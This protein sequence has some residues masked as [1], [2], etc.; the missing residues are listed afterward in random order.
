[1]FEFLSKG[2]V[3]I[4]TAGVVAGMAIG[5]AIYPSAADDTTSAT[6]EEAASPES[7]GE[8]ANAQDP[9]VLEA[10]L[11]MATMAAD[12]PQMA[13]SVSLVLGA[14]NPDAGTMIY[15]DFCAA[16]HGYDG[17]SLLPEAPSFADG[18]IFKASDTDLFISVRDGKGDIMPPW[19]D[20]ITVAEMFAALKYAKKFAPDKEPGEGEAAEPAE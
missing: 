7:D 15:E 6:T 10:I 11:A 1:M 4:A 20:E 16:C 5:L 18:E 19:T 8:T 9:A 17:V 12:D 13:S 3:H 14:T 2:R